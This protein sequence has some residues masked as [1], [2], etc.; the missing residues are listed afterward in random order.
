MRIDRQPAPHEARVASIHA[1][2]GPANGARRQRLGCIA[3]RV[4]RDGPQASFFCMARSR[5]QRQCR[6]DRMPVTSPSDDF[7]MHAAAATR[8]F[9]VSGICPVRSP[10]LQRRGLSHAVFT[11]PPS[12]ASAIAKE[13]YMNTHFERT[14]PLTEITSYPQWAQDMVADCQSTKQTVLDHELWV[15]MRECTL[16]LTATTNFMVGI[17]PFIERFPGYMALN[18]LKTQ[19]GRSKG[20][21]MARRWLVR[22]IRVEQ[23]HAE[24]WLNWGEGAGISR[25]VLLH[26]AA[27][28]G[29]DGLAKWC[30]E[31]SKSGTLA[32]GMVATNYA[33][34]GVTGE[35]SHF[36]YESTKYRESF[37]KSVRASSVRWLHLHADYDD[38]HPWEAL[39]IVCTLLG[40]NPL[41]SE[42]AHLGEC[43]KR[44]YVSMRI[45]GDKCLQS[46]QDLW[47]VKEEAA[48]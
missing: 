33:I 39:E 28:K 9:K 23:N 3:R 11:P 32:A 37:E 41:P 40:T 24:Y 15:M 30:E 34:E 8:P 14:G 46:R 2:I 21:D 19:Y 27:P 47:S 12:N 48:A 42:V 43:I 16:G 1:M 25:D 29:T 38:T 36:V 10:E 35:W 5:A 4:G 26:G 13:F 31:I 17:W 22:N 45:L 44:S 18:L 6:L 20:E 7:L